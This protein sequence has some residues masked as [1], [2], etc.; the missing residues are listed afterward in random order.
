MDHRSFISAYR[1][2]AIQL[3][4]DPAGAARYLSARL[5][6]PL[7]MMPIVGAG[8]ALALTGWLWTGIVVMA[9]GIIAPRLIKRSAPHFVLTQALEDERVYLELTRMNV[10][11]ISRIDTGA[12][13]KSEGNF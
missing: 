13:S 4:I 11:R 9:A 12:G 2:G 5:L 3:Q 6:L 7:V 1:S 10:L 8:M